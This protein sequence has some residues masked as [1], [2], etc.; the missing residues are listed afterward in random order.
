MGLYGSFPNP[1]PWMAGLLFKDEHL[2]EHTPQKQKNPHFAVR[3]S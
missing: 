2:F 1:R 3:A